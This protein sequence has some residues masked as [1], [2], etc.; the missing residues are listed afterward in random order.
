MKGRRRRGDGRT[1]NSAREQNAL[2]PCPSPE[3]GRGVVVG[4][5]DAKTLSA[6]PTFQKSF[7][8][9]EISEFL[10]KCGPGRLRASVLSGNPECRTVQ[11]DG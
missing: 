10:G 8:R 9:Q 5:L 7:R 3:Y 2:T 11:I 1:G 6:L 4:H